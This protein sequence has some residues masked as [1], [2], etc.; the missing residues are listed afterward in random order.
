MV[1]AKTPVPL[2]GRGVSHHQRK[3]GNGYTLLDKCTLLGIEL[4]Q[5]NYGEWYLLGAYRI[6]EVFYL[7][8]Y[9]EIK[10]VSLRHDLVKEWNEAQ[11]RSFFNHDTTGL[12]DFLD[13]YGETAYKACK[14]L[15]ASRRKKV[16]K[17][18]KKIGKSVKTGRAYFVTLTFRD[19]VLA[20]TSA[21]TRRRYVSRFLKEKCDR[22]VANI[23]YGSKKEREHYHAIV[24]PYFWIFETY[25]NGLRTYHDMPD[26]REWNKYGYFSVEAVGDSEEDLTKVAKYTAKLSA[27][28]VKETTLK[29]ESTPRL[30]YSRRQFRIKSLPI[31]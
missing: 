15:D 21:K 14:N 5:A 23:D 3:F 18:R 19:E 7:V 27:H 20:K 16:S 10:K 29:G 11:K 22:Y 26:F 1:G 9:Q 2:L 17:A 25:E 4:G 6:T 8:D 12:E 24:E 31:L 28:A 30:I 13:C